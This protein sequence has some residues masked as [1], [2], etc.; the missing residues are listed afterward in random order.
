MS[1]T[2]TN[3]EPFYVLD[4]HVLIWYLQNDPR[5][6]PTARAVFTAAEA[7]RTVLVIS[8]IVM[9]ELYYVNR[10][11]KWFADFEAVFNL[12]TSKSFVR[13]IAVEHSHVLD[14]VQD[15]N[16]PEMHDRIIAGVARRMG[17]PWVTMDIAITSAGVARVIW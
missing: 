3:L 6:S 15:D 5:L 4:T 11:Q 7:N 1:S 2:L 16:I 8:A 17:A 13:F 9:A 10:K 14:F 12:M